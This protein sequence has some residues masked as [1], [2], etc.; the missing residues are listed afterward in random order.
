MTS[1]LVLALVLLGLLLSTVALWTFFLRLVPWTKA[2]EATTRRIVVAIATVI[3]LQVAINLLLFAIAPESE[4]LSTVLGLAG[5]AASVGVACGV[6][7]AVFRVSFVQALQAWIPMLLAPAATLAL[8]LVV[9]KPFLFEAYRVPTNAMAP[10]L[11]GRHWK[12]TCSK[13]G[14]P[15]YCSPRDDRYA[16][17]ERPRMICD[18]FHVTVAAELDSTIHAS[19]RFLVAKL[20]AP[21]RWDLVVFRSPETPSQLY[22]SRLIGL[23]GETV[24]IKDGAVWIDGVRQTPPASIGGIEYLSEMPDGLGPDLWGSEAR[25]ATLSD[26]E[27]FVLGDFSPQSKDSRFWERGAPGHNPFAVPASYITGVVTHTYWP[28]ERW[29]I[30]R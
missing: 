4:S 23:P 9:V 16:T 1:T 11:V 20:F 26:D 27:Y 15:N 12:G 3:V 25:P 7:C 17:D 6:V 10:T 2:P 28:V 21:R 5:L 30:H 22:V 19:D 13:C 14:K 29:R 18:S 24:L 8:L